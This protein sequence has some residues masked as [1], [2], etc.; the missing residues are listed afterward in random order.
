MLNLF[1]QGDSDTA[2]FWGGWSK[3]LGPCAWGIFSGQHY[4]RAPW[5]NME[6]MINDASLGAPSSALFPFFGEGSPIKIDC[7]KKGSLFLT[8]LLEDLDRFFQFSMYQR[9]ILSVSFLGT[10]WLWVPIAGKIRDVFLS[11]SERRVGLWISE[12]ASVC[13]CVCA[14]F[15]L[16]FVLFF[17]IFSFLHIVNFLYQFGLD[18]FLPSTS[19]G[20]D[21]FAWSVTAGGEGGQYLRCQWIRPNGLDAPRGCCVRLQSRFAGCPSEP[22]TNSQVLYGGIPE[23]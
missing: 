14:C 18:G 8:S 16:L 15:V 3:R 21:G 6:G 19:A 22:K 7:R 20:A 23:S 11:L 10:G 2:G 17:S 1:A 13:V 9:S 4:G 12:P 5:C